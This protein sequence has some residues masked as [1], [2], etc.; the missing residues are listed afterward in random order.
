MFNTILSPERDRI[1]RRPLDHWIHDLETQYYEYLPLITQDF[2]YADFEVI[3]N[4]I[5]LIAFYLGKKDLAEE[6][7]KTS[8]RFFFDAY[9]T[10]VAQAKGKNCPNK[11][12]VIQPWINLI[13]LDR[14]LGK[15]SDSKEKLQEIKYQN[16]TYSLAGHFLKQADIS[17]QA[18]QLMSHCYMDE[19]IKIH[20]AQKSYDVILNFITEIPQKQHL[21]KAQILFLLET[22]AIVSRHTPDAVTIPFL[23][24]NIV[25]EIPEEEKL[26][27]ALKYV[28]WLMLENEGQQAKEHLKLIV[29]NF[30]YPKNIPLFKLRLWLQVARTCQEIGLIDELETLSLWLYK[31]FTEQDDALSVLEL[32]RM[33]TSTSLSSPFW[34]TIIEQSTYTKVKNDPPIDRPSWVEQGINFS[35]TLLT[36]MNKQIATN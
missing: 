18:I 21:Y 7:C 8:Q 23:L 24:Q 2:P 30:D 1:S 28:H 33:V 12:G 31:A 19:Y 20:L 17:R 4:N 10:K 5:S 29:A 26:V 34:K 27:F 14:F 3:L 13:R 6:L 11:F 22:K 32:A 25:D 35:T 9:V 15:F 36:F 16:D